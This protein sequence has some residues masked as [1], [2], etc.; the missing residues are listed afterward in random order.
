MTTNQHT[1]DQAVRHIAQVPT[2]VLTSPSHHTDAQ[3]RL[4]DVMA[5][6][7][8]KWNPTRP[9]QP[10]RIGQTRWVSAFGRLRR[11]IVVKVTPTKTS[12]AYVV[13]TSPHDIKVAT[14]RHDLV[15]VQA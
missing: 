13:P 10:H 9:E 5:T 7:P 11:G 2:H 3:H 6:K 14:A 15:L 8:D 12:V 1:V 4:R